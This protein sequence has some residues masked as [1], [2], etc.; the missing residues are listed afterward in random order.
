MAHILIID[1]DR[2]FAESLISL[3]EDLHHQVACVESATRA[4]AL[5]YDAYDVVLLDNRMPGMSGIEFLKVLREKAI[6]IPVILMTNLGTSETVME[7]MELGAFDYIEKPLDLDDLI[8]ELEPM[9]QE[10]F[11]LRPASGVHPVPTSEAANLMRGKSKSMLGVYKQIGQIAKTDLP[12]LIRGETGTGKELVARAIHNHSPRKDKPFVA[13]NCTSLN[14]NLLDDELFGHVEGA[15]SDA[16]KLRKGRFEYADQ[17]TLFLD[18]VGDMPPVL[19]AKLLRVLENKEVVRI[20]SN[21]TIRVDVRILSA[22]HQ[23]LE[24]AVKAGR[25]R[26]DLLFRLNGTTLSLPPLRE[27]EGDVEQLARHFLADE[28]AKA[29]RPMPTL[30]KSALELLKKHPW[31]GNVRELQFVIRRAVQKCRGLQILPD[32]LELPTQTAK[33]G[34]EAGPEAELKRVVEWAWESAEPKLWPLLSEMLERPMIEHG[35]KEC[36]GNKRELARRLGVSPNYLLKRIREFG[37][38]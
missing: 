15:F 38:E 3:L 32:D 31:P 33:A 22:T 6:L 12:V 13:L 9:L 19:Q 25:F 26:E 14:E 7:A 11:K 35:L 34:N 37:L 4:S 23:D 20:G 21:E 5:S 29:N 2:D 8:D 30:H 36:G 27:R 1:D 24:A 16:K 28:A 18:E 10:A 17:G